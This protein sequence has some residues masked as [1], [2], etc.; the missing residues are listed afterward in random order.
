MSTATVLNLLEVLKNS[1]D[2]NN[3]LK[4]LVKL[5]T[6]IVKDRE[7]IMLFKNS[8]GIPPLIKFLNRP[9]EKILE[10]ALSILGN[11]CTD[12]E[13]C[14]QA[15]ENKIVPSLVTI[16]K[17]VPNPSIQCRAC[18]LLGNLAKQ[19]TSKFL[20]YNSSISQSLCLI[21]EESIEDQTTIMGVRAA[22]YL[23]SNKEFIKSFIG[24]GG[25]KIILQILIK[26]M[27]K[28]HIEVQNTLNDDIDVK[29]RVGLKVQEHREK[30]FQEVARH[31]E[32]VR[33]DIFDNEMLKSKKKVILFTM[34]KEKSHLDIVHEILKCVHLISEIPSRESAAELHSPLLSLPCIIYFANESNPFRGLSLRIIS[35]FSRNPYAVSSL[36]QAD[37]AEA[38]CTLLMAEHLKIPLSNSE[39]KCCIHSL[40]VLAGDACNRAKIRRS[41]AL[42]K[43]LELA[44]KS[45]SYS[46]VSLILFVLINFQYD[47]L[48][49]DFMSREGLVDMLVK[50]LEAFLNS[51]DEVRKK[52]V[53]EKLARAQAKK[54]KS[55]AEAIQPNSKAAKW[56]EFYD[57]DSPVGSPLNLSPF[58]P[59][60]SRSLSPVSAKVMTENDFESETYSPVCSEDE[61]DSED[62]SNAIKEKTSD[63]CDVM[64]LLD[65]A[66]KTETNIEENFSDFEDEKKDPVQMTEKIFSRNA[67]DIIDN[68]LFRV[69]LLTTN[70]VELGKPQTLNI[71]IQAIN[72]FGINHS[73]FGSC[74]TNILSD[75]KFFLKILK[76]NVPHQLYKMTRI[77]DLKSG[78]VNFIDT[79]TCVAET[80]YGRGEIA[81]L[82]K[83]EIDHQKR[84]AI[85]I[86]FIIKS[87]SFLY[88]LLTENDVLNILLA[89]IL[90]KNDELRVEAADGIT[91]IAQTLGIAT[92]RCH[93]FV[94][95]TIKE[96]DELIDFIETCNEN[97]NEDDVM[98]FLI[99]R[100]CSQIP[101]K[102]SKTILSHNSEVFNSMLN[103]DFRENK[104]GEVHLKDYTVHGIKYFLNLINLK[105]KKQPL[106][107]PPVYHFDSILEAYE[108]SRMYIMTDLEKYLFEMLVHRLDL[109]SCLRVFEWSLTHFNPELS[110]IAI[111]YYLSSEI[112]GKDKVDLFRDADYSK[113]SKEWYQ[114][115]TDA[116]LVKCQNMCV[117]FS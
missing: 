75:S 99:H 3:L 81:K 40:N 5:R 55:P 104:E 89:T 78:G 57:E 1:T 34:P 67:I 79:L 62:E 117:D 106:N 103:S 58:S 37:A 25:F 84:G 60:S 88:S 12:E 23:L 7:G 68:L 38:A 13:C 80:G 64:K 83:N 54:R 52:K 95:N 98:K 4:A 74:L 28:D 39:L 53:E 30:Y 44:K 43:L 86:S 35:N 76:Q 100:G 105:S 47:N 20:N 48:S 33:N 108:L 8:Q 61:A 82:L 22:R 111:N 112:D 85:A 116:I 41:G 11:A 115:I 69:S 27:K 17:S 26:E 42:Q 70:R 72:V 49:I 45:K 92:P 29:K 63:E 96:F 87:P 97:E 2:K 9:N 94:F 77:E 107:I 36:S 65:I 90:N 46:E 110:E 21:L 18:R 50:E 93:K 15:F 66:F 32:G 6:D 71:I 10:I 91:S 109:K 51:D 73:S 31:L 102:F 101:V 114:M 56:E 16:L 113:F 14:T 19:N 24:N 59:C